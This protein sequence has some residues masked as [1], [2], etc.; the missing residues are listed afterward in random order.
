MK[1][2]LKLIA[3]LM[4][5]TMIFAG[6]NKG[7][8]SGLPPAGVGETGYPETMPD[9][10][11]FDPRTYSVFG[12]RLGQNRCTTGTRI[13]PTVEDMCFF[14]QHEATNKG[15][16]YEQ[17]VMKFQQNCGNRPFDP[18]L[19]RDQLR[20]SGKL[21][22]CFL[23]EGPQRRGRNRN[24]ARNTQIG[25]M[26]HRDVMLMQG[27]SSRAVILQSY[28][29]VTYRVRIDLYDRSARHL[30]R[31]EREWRNTPPEPITAFA[32][33]HRMKPSVSC[34]PKIRPKKY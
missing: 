28:D 4:L 2:T 30:T 16:A 20:N 6:C 23:T 26:S 25:Q 33:A 27:E 11:P 12:Y 19:A 17:R 8:G 14:L 13:Y 22:N 5:G 31:E 7:G 18:A 24:R 15:C 10:N 32:S 29:G 3:V 34:I 9:I 21:I 1:N